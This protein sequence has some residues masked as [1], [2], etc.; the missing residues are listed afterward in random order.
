MQLTVYICSYIVLDASVNS[1]GKCHHHVILSSSLANSSSNE[2]TS[3]LMSQKSADQTGE[4][5]QTVP[6]LLVSVELMT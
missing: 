4:G 1:F 6:K 3:L 2:C 5:E